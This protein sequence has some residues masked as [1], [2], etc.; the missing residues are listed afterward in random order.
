MP[1]PSKKD[2]LEA[3]K[4]P[5]LLKEAGLQ[6][7]TDEEEKELFADIVLGDND[8]IEDVVRKF[9]DKQKKQREY[10]RK[11]E[12]KIL[13]AAEE[14]AGEGEA[15]RQQ[16]EVDAFLKDH[17]ALSANK[18]LLDIVEPLYA[19]GMSLE[20]AYSKGC[21]SLD[22]DPATGKAPEEEKKEEKKSEEKKAT[23]EKK[24]K[25]TAF[26]S[27][28]VDDGLPGVAHEEAE[29]GRERPKTIREI[30]S[31]HSNALAAK[32][33]NPYRDS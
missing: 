24:E 15:A 30:A 1:K 20:D 17:P 11:R 33:E 31:E 29:E 18:D 10:L 12:E 27:N 5:A 3:M 25:K 16:R 32:G 19:N 7:I 26:K 8:S 21:K 23:E 13:K 9:N 2:L 14:K 22:L 4:D 28:T 6:P